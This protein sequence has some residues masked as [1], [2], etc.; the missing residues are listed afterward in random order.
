MGFWLSGHPVK[1]SLS[2]FIYSQL[3]TLNYSTIF[4]DRLIFILIGFK[5]LLYF[6]PIEIIF[7]IEATI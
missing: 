1:T 5:T 7:A 3:T 6:Q 4:Y 2:N